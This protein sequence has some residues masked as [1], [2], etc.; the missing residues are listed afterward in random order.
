MITSFHSD[1]SFRHVFGL[2]LST[3]SWYCTFSESDHL[4][5]TYS[6][7]GFV[8]ARASAC[9]KIELVLTLIILCYYFLNSP[10]ISFT[11]NTNALKGNHFQSHH[12]MC[13]FWFIT[14]ICYTKS[15]F[16]NSV[17]EMITFLFTFLK[18]EKRNHVKH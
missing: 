4:S 7:S 12:F 17:M 11:A 10:Q 1:T 18:N 16:F 5:G 8:V 14:E 13:T 6:R 2:I 15:F 9:N 3:W